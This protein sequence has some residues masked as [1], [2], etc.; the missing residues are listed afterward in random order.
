MA[1]KGRG[2]P[3]EGTPEY[4]WLYGTTGSAGRPD[5]DATQVIRGGEAGRP[6]AGESSESD[7]RTKV[8]PVTPPTGGSTSGPGG[9]PPGGTATATQAPPPRPAAPRQRRRR[10]FRWVLVLLLLWAVFLV[11]VPFWAWSKVEKVDAWPSGDR[12]ADQP[13]TTYLI[14]GSDSRKGLS[15]EERQ[16]LHT[17]GDVGQRTDTIMLLHTGDGPNLLMSIPRDSLVPIEGHGTTKINAAFAY[18]GAP[19]L[20]QTVERNTGIRIDHYVEIGFGGFVGAVD[21]VGGIEICPTEDMVDKDADLDIKKGCQEVDGKV[22]LAYA[23]SRK[24]SS[25][26]DI[27]RARRQREVVSAV[28]KKAVSPMSVINPVRYFRLSDAASGAFAV[29]EGSSPW[30]I[31]HFAWAMTKVNGDDGLTCGVPIVDLGVHWDPERSAEMFQHIIDDDTAGISDQLC[32]PS[33]LP[34]AQG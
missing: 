6:A 17:G 10:P 21:A 30:A 32:T 33:G 12:P 27:D 24:T 25:L 18:G 26:G 19:L 29:S 15:K 3:E 7:D 2:V 16:D 28:G 31:A 4:E 1:D 22:A 13:G 9:R 8:M 14:V 11:A 5:D 23:R 34:K 20:V